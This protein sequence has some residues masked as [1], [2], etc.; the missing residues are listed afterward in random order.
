LLARVRFAPDPT[1]IEHPVHKVTFV[2]KPLEGVSSDPVRREVPF[3]TPE[4]SQ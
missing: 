2:I 4:T 3:S 1:G